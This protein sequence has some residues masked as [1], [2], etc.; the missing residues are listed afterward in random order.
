MAATTGE[1]RN[2]DAWAGV[3]PSESITLVCTPPGDDASVALSTA[4]PAQESWPASRF[5]QQDTS[6]RDALFA[7]LSSRPFSPLST[8]PKSPLPL[9][10][11]RQGGGGG[12][13]IGGASTP[14]AGKGGGGPTGGGGGGPGLVNANTFMGDNLGGAGSASQQDR[15]TVG[16]AS[17]QDPAAGTSPST[18]FQTTYAMTAPTQAGLSYL[19]TPASGHGNG[20]GNGNGDGHGNEN[21]HGN[22]HDRGHDHGQ[23][24]S[25]SSDPL[26]VL[27]MNT[28]ETIPANVTLNTFST[29]SE[30]LLAQ[31]SGGALSSVSWDTSGAP[32]LTNISGTNTLNLQG[33]WA[34]FTGAARSE[35]ISVTETPQSGSPITMTMT[36]AVAGTD[37]PAYSST[38]PTS[39]STWPTVITPDQLLS[40]QPTQA[41]GPYASIGEVDGSVQTSFAMPSY[42]PNTTP[43]SL[44]YNSTTANPQ[45]IFLTEYQ[46]P[47]GQSVPSTITAQ[48]TFDGTALSTVTYDTS[49][50]NAGDIMQVALQADAT[51]LSTGRYPW[52]I[53]VTNGSNQTTYSGDVDIVNQASSA[54][55]AGWSLDNVE[56]LVSVSGGMMLVN[57]DGTSLYFASNGQG[58]YTTQA[59]DFSTLVQNEDD[60]FTQTL[61]DGTQINFN[62]SGQETSTVD[63]NGN[64]TSLARAA[65]FLG[66]T[67]PRSV[68]IRVLPPICAA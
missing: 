32:D 61:T 34:S 14:N 58:G 37:S 10:A 19:A 5:S 62:S 63:P 4:T 13:G 24:G 20:D 56:Q 48:L 1:T 68:S 55:G 8:P 67:N 42:N 12:R 54:F 50:L 59:G 26:Y 64:T 44:D 17:Q 49:E 25:S 31:V 21:G 9:P 52:S 60:N 3:P 66:T 40:G 7:P 39:S 22:G 47:T 36:F 29:W 23:S 41:A 33:T 16:P 35:T 57:P 51:D 43:V 15:G 2:S 28:G 38:Q 30:D 45:P 65:A 46:L 53:V 18:D 11:A 6:A 27:D